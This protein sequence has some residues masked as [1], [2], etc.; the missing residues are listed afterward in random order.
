MSE[1]WF[2][3]T[4]WTAIAQRDFEARLKRA[5]PYNRP[6]YLR[7]KAIALR[8]HGG[9][10]YRR[11]ARQLNE[12]IVRDYPYSY[13]D[14]VVAHEQLGLI[15]EEELA[16]DDAMDHYRRALHLSDEGAP[17]GDAILRLP[18][19]LIA[20]DPDSDR[21]EEAEAIL[22]RIDD[23]SLAFSSQ[24]FRYR[25]LRARLADRHGDKD[26][27]AAL[28]QSALAEWRRAQPDF[29]RHPDLGWVRTTPEVIEEL[30]RLSQLA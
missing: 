27:A 18:E 19:L 16:L 11:A 21:L 29:H 10:A 23:Q 4:E 6:Q 5:R 26:A 1:D 20:G 15:A 7:A 9:E 2:R 25:A 14:L 22:A 3:T 24:R 28:A 30:Q 12:R 17:H 8:E 13:L